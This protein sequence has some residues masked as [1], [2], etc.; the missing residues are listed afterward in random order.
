MPSVRA[1][2]RVISLTSRSCIT[3]SYTRAKS[4]EYLIYYIPENLSKY[5]SPKVTSSFY[6]KHETAEKVTDTNQ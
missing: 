1:C 5:G 2:P 3:R 4:A 6:V